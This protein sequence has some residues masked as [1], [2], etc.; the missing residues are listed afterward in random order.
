M[1]ELK[2]WSIVLNNSTSDVSIVLADWDEEEGPIIIKSTIPDDSEDFKDP[3]DVLI[4]RFYMSAQPIFDHVGFS[5]INF[6]LP[7]LPLEKLAI[8]FFDLV[9]DE[10]VRRSQRPFLLVIFTH[11]D[12]NYAKI[13]DIARVSEPFLKDY[14][15]NITPDLDTLKA[16]LSDELTKPERVALTT[17][18]LIDEVII[19]ELIAEATPSS[20]KIVEETPTDEIAA[21]DPEIDALINSIPMPVEE[22]KPVIPEIDPD[23]IGEKA[24]PERLKV[25]DAKLEKLI[26]PQAVQKDLVAPEPVYDQ[27]IVGEPIIIDDETEEKSPNVAF[28]N[29]FRPIREDIDTSGMDLEAL[30]ASE[31]D[32]MDKSQSDLLFAKN[33]QNL[34]Y[35]LL[36]GQA[37][38]DLEKK[39]HRLKMLEQTK[40][41]QELSGKEEPSKS[42]KKEKEHPSIPAMTP[43][44]MKECPECSALNPKKS[45][46][47]F[48]CGGK[49]ESTYE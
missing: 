9:T 47:C 20:E 32:Y 24:I 2:E 25:L 3:I 48:K 33:F 39:I 16:L 45:K 5:K 6:N 49:F 21:S 27:T 38:E 41:L 22:S 8:I 44:Q 43:E 7:L 17:A 29:F 30:V 35:K 42:K 12:T 11:L 1:K 26:V 28:M 31:I 37:R 23:K 18:P 15:E 14:R 46:F 40:R 34:G 19:D 36:K 13:E 4:T 10:S